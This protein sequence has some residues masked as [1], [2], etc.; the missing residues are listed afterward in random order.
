MV[1][2]EFTLYKFV[3]TNLDRKNRRLENR[4]RT[5]RITLRSFRLVE[6]KK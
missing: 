3:R 6:T 4:R 5:Y 2:K 1:G